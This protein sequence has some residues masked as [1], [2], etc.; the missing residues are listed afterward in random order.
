ML[1]FYYDGEDVKLVC[2]LFNTS[3]ITRNEVDG[4]AIHLTRTLDYKR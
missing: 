4:R 1:D 3:D 2:R